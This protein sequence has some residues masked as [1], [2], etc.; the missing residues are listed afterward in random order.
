MA[1]IVTSQKNIH[2]RT[3]DQL[4]DLI[5]S[6]PPTELQGALISDFRKNAN[7]NPEEEAK[8]N[9]IRY[10]VIKNRVVGLIDGTYSAGLA[11]RV[12]KE[13]ITTQLGQEYATLTNIAQIQGIPVTER[14]VYELNKGAVSLTGLFHPQETHTIFA[15]DFSERPVTFS[16]TTY[17]GTGDEVVHTYYIRDGLGQET[18]GIGRTGLTTDYQRDLLEYWGIPQVDPQ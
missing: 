9:P 4:V 17:R 5:K 3:P 10:A 7:P 1:E 6:T 13:G 12:T 8:A 16:V 15:R 14:T 2:P 11:R 18:L